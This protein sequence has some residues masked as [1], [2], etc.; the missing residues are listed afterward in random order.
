MGR[1]AAPILGRTA[2]RS[3]PRLQARG[4]FR[5]MEK[6]SSGEETKRKRSKGADGVEATDAEMAQTG[7]LFITSC[8]CGNCDGTGLAV[9]MDHRR[10]P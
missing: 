9:L 2:G 10:G 8:G 6:V 7:A 3:I 1:R 5:R 4:Q